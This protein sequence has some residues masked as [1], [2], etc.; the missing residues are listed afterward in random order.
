M[1]AALLSDNDLV[2][3]VIV[4]MNDKCT[5]SKMKGRATGEKGK[6]KLCGVVL[7]PRCQLVTAKTEK[8]Y[9]VVWMDRKQDCAQ[10]LV[11]IGRDETITVY[12]K[13]GDSLSSQ[14]SCSINFRALDTDAKVEIDFVTFSIQAQGIKLYVIGDGSGNSVC[15]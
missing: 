6:R 4:K 12:A 9:F 14:G 7:E 1:P 3:M 2:V 10:P 13:S 15:I 8:I 5:E 11:E